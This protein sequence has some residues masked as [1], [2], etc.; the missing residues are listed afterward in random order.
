M[1]NDVSRL[2]KPDLFDGLM[3]EGTDPVVSYGVVAFT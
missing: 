2:I 3:K 1:A